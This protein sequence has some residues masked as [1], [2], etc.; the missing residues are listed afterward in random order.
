MILAF[1][2]ATAATVVACGDGRR[3]AW[4][5]HDPAAGERPGHTA[6]LLR[7]A[8]E[9]TAELRGSLADVTRIGVGV[10]PGSFTGLRIG[11]TAARAL[12]QSLDVEA[13]AVSS[14]ALLAWQEA[15]I[16]VAIDARRGE[17]F[18][19]R[20]VAGNALEGPR[21]VPAHEIEQL[22]PG[23]VVGDGAI[24]YRTEFEAAGFTVPADRDDAHRVDA[25]A[26]IALTTELKVTPIEQLLPDYVRAP[27]AKPRVV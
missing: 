22:L 21:A 23:W 5:R 26:L 9:V 19:G 4:R 6:L 3:V 7:F 16:S 17:V 20:Y 24:R 18:Y 12:A 15:E 27:D 25:N 14:L 13:V 2:T 10:G 1:D 11:V 8:H